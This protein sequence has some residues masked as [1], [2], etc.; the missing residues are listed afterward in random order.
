MPA[1]NLISLRSMAVILSLVYLTACINSET[2]VQLNPDGSG[3]II[4]KTLFSQEFVQQMTQMFK[5]MVDQI[6]QNSSDNKTAKGLDLF[7]EE[8]A[9]KRASIFGE[10]V[11]FVSSQKIQNADWEGL[12]AIFEF[13]DIRKVHLSETPR[14]SGLSGLQAPS[15]VES[16]PTTF[17]FTRL[18]NGNSVLTV[19]TPPLEKKDREEADDESEE[20]SESSESVGSSG[21]AEAVKKMFAGFRIASSI[22]VQGT[23]HRT[24]FPYREGSRLTLLEIDFAQLLANEEKFKEFQKHQPKTLDEAKLLLKEVKGIKI[25]LDSKMQ[26]EFH[27]R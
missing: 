25:P 20:Q 24:N 15:S 1:C 7:S 6:G 13:K 3:R 26:V 10:G 11:T 22:D 2:V 12:E 23:I 21:N 17:E 14:Q 4:E 8:S 19:V 27:G 9:R 5:G 16:K 18:P